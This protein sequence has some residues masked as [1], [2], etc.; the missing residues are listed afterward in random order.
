MSLLNDRELTILAFKEAISRETH[1]SAKLRHIILTSRHRE[2]S[3]TCREL[4]ASCRTR[5]DILKKEAKNLN[6]K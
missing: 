4:L 5:I 6:I 3:D 2:V 1:M